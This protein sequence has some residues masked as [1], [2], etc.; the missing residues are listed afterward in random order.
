MKEGGKQG[1]IACIVIGNPLS[2]AI[3]NLTKINAVTIKKNMDAFDVRVSFNG[4]YE[5]PIK[6]PLMGGNYVQFIFPRAYV[7]PAKQ[8]IRTDGNMIQKALLYQYNKRTVRLRLFI[9]SQKLNS[10]LFKKIR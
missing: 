5:V 6:K 8:I 7:E 3:N 10:K 2:A 4:R 1:L 9:D